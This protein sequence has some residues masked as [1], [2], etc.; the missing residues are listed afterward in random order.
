MEL[1][2]HVEE[3]AGL[4]FKSIFQKLQDAKSGLYGISELSGNL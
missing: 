4:F 2:G 1:V 3:A